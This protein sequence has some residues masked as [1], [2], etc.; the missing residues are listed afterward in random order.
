M[1]LRERVAGAGVDIERFLNEDLPSV[2]TAVARYASRWNV[3]PKDAMQE[4]MRRA[5]ED[6][7]RFADD[8]E[9]AA[10]CVGTGRKVVMEM[11]RQGSR[12]VPH[13]D[14]LLLESAIEST[15]DTADVVADRQR[16]DR[17]RQQVR[18]A[19]G[20][21]GERDRALLLGVYVEDKSYR[22]VGIELDMTED[23][24]RLALFR[25]R[26]KMKAAL[27][28]ASTFAVAPLLMLLNA[29]AWLGRRAARLT[30]RGEAGV[31]VT[32][33]AIVG[34][35]AVSVT[36]SPFGVFPLTPTPPAEAA[37]GQPQSSKQDGQGQPAPAASTA[38]LPTPT[39]HDVPQPASGDT[40]D[41][42][43][44]PSEEMARVCANG[45]FYVCQAAWLST[46]SG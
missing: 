15:P 19:L 35:V 8:G 32:Q 27:Q 3:D 24:V 23:A 38:A 20:E 1:H 12:A 4:T 46:S 41:P 14:L 30:T 40:P 45:C 10:W 33:A 7:G 18:A 44:S 11:H 28:S 37:P 2:D 42:E 31:T 17:I 9:L 6:L 43:P 29:A 39:T 21:L 13:G 16:Q 22:A 36:V 25:T 5:L 26:R 34:L